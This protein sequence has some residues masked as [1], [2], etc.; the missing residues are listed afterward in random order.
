MAEGQA[1]Y[2]RLRREAG[3]AGLAGAALVTVLVPLA[4]AAPTA[5]SFV[6]GSSLGA[7]VTHPTR[8]ALAQLELSGVLLLI[9]LGLGLVGG[10]LG[11][12]GEGGGLSLRGHPVSRRTRLAAR[13]LS[14]ALELPPMLAISC[15]AGL[16]A[17]LSVAQPAMTPLALL[18]CA[19]AS[20]WVLIVQYLVR[21]LRTLGLARPVFALSTL[22]VLGLLVLS[23]Q[24]RPMLLAAG[25][26]LWDWLPYSPTTFGVTGFVDL[27]S[28]HLVAGWLRQLLPL[29]V[30]VLA[31]E[32]TAQKAARA[33]GND[34]GPHREG[35]AP[36]RLWTFNTPAQGI[37]RLFISAVT[38]SREGLT[39]ILLPPFIV[40]MIVAVSSLMANGV[41][42]APVP[43]FFATMMPESLAA[44]PVF[45]LLPFL[46]VHVNSEMWLNQWGWDGRAV[47]T[48]FVAPITM[49]DLL[50]GKLMGLGTI[51]VAQYLMAMPL[52]SL[53][54]PPR[55]AE[56]SWG[57]G[58]GVFAHFV[59]VGLGHV[60]SAGLCRPLDA[61]GR[62]RRTESFAAMI[63]GALVLAAALAPVA[64]TYSIARKWG[65]WA[66]SVSLWALAVAGLVGYWRSLPFLEKR[67][68]EMREEFLEA[69]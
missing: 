21:A 40:G 25:R 54:R 7:D 58:A 8:G 24:G 28:G 60:L 9:P 62:I 29:A 27:A 64:L 56:L 6:V 61:S 30:T 63:A 53:L 68:R 4:L 19:Q 45:G 15:L 10:F 3:G 34:P 23:R 37:A 38:R 46:L 36:E 48:L 57:L 18:L 13:F 32:I 22:A 11:G 39:L 16:T 44:L 43:P 49:R 31:I 55:A 69:A 33:E 14:A 66:L 1:L 17:G 35:S 20:V 51:V 50:L 12:E 59:V 65:D 5:G 26:V 67:V 42:R 47:R 41:R 52:L 2:N